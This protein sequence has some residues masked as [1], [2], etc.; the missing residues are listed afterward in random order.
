MVD[1]AQTGGRE[2][3]TKVRH[4]LDLILKPTGFSPCRQ[5]GNNHTTAFGFD[6][7][8]EFWHDIQHMAMATGTS[9]DRCQMDLC[10]DLRTRHKV[11]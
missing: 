4:S 8:F 9:S 1:E 7:E 10:L 11:P 2:D 3:A 6:H 5:Q